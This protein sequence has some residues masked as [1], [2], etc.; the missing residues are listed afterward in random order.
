MVT[1][2]CAPKQRQPLYF[3]RRVAAEKRTFGHCRSEVFQIAP[4][5]L[6]LTYAVGEHPFTRRNAVLK[7]L[8]DW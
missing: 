8:T 1:I 7:A 6:S 5:C 2:R 3:E 4:T